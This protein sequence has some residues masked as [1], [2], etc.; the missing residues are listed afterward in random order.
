MKH[1]KPFAAAIILI[2]LVSTIVATSYVILNKQKEKPQK[3]FYVGVTYG[4]DSVQEAKKL[5]DQVKN[6]TNLFILA[7]RG[8]YIDLVF[9][10]EIGDYAIASNLNYAVFAGLG[11]R[12]ISSWLNE[13]KE[14][15]G[16]YFTGV[17]FNDEPGGKMLDSTIILE[18]T[19]TQENGGINITNGIIKEAGGALDCNINGTRITYWPDGRLSVQLP[20]STDEIFEQEYNSSPE[21]RQ[22]VNGTIIGSYKRL[23]VKI[24]YYPNGMITIDESIYEGILKYL[25][26]EYNDNNSYPYNDYIS[27]KIVSNFYTAENITKYPYEIQSYEEILNQNPIQNYNDV[28]KAFVNVENEVL[29]SRFL[30]KTRLEETILVF[31]SDY[32]L[33]W[34]DYQKGYDFILAEVGWNNSITQEIGLLRGAANLQNKNWGTIITWKYDQ[35]PF[36]AGGNEIYQQMKISYEAGAEYVIIFNYSEDKTNPNT[37]QE[38][39]FQ[40]LERF[41]NDVVQ[42]PKIAHGNIR[43]NA[44]LVLPEN[45]GW[46]MRHPNDTIWGIWPPDN[47]SQQIWEQLQSKLDKHGLKLDIVFEDPN[48]PVT[49]RYSNIYYWNQK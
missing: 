23:N 38:E 15:W 34:W 3:P 49:G 11:D 17:Y 19:I 9:V 14:R 44:V 5:I 48:Y 37:L 41:W 35:T 43:A 24:N 46:G 22:L 7:S 1:L 32:G 21:E 40:A 31:T 33:Y 30:N 36:L 8:L 4:G 39:H 25:I 27:E 45:Y 6:Y 16:E 47:I 20:M 10:E 29:S 42:N 26:I 13:A 12:G 28:A 2:L 18:N